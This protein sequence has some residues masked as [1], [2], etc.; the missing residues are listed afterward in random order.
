MEIRSLE[1]YHQTYQKSVET[2]EAFWKDIAAEFVWRKAP[3][4]ILLREYNKTE[5]KWFADGEL[6]ITEN[7]LD[8]HN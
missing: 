8:Q 5:V 3:E 7:C 2:P 6:K 4:S 1:Q